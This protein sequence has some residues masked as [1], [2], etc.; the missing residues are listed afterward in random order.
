MIRFYFFHQLH[1][2][3]NGD[4]G[5]NKNLGFNSTHQEYCFSLKCNHRAKATVQ[6]IELLKTSLQ[7]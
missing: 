1:R 2:C 7:N 3:F 5:K 4:I 6:L